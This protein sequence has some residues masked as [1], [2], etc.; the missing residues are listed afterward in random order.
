[1][2]EAKKMYFNASVSILEFCMSDNVHF[3][4]CES[5]FAK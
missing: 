3:R 2:Y 1:M 4:I 5:Y